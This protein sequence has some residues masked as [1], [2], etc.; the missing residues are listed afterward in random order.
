MKL[1]VT[2]PRVLYLKVRYRMQLW[3]RRQA[4]I[5][6]EERMADFEDKVYDNI[7]DSWR[8]QC[9]TTAGIIWTVLTEIFWNSVEVGWAG[10]A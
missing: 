9:P 5:P 6:P 8:R 4:E 7:L 1:G 10:E 3:A 2:S